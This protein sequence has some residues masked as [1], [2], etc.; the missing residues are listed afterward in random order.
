MDEPDAPWLKTLPVP[1][2]ALG[3]ARTQFS[4][5][6]RWC[7]WLRQHLH[8]FDAIIVHGLWRYPSVGVWRVCHPRR[9][10]FVYVHGM[11]DPKFRRLF[12]FKHMAKT[13]TWK[14]WEHRVVRDAAA[15]LFTCA[16][17][18][19]L[20]QNSFR[21]YHAREAIVPYC[22]AEPPGDPPSQR[23]AFESAFPMLQGKTIILFLSR[24]HPKKGCDVLL[25][26]FSRVAKLHPALRLVMAG[27]DPVGWQAA[28]ERHARQLGV[29]DR[30]LWTG[31]LTGD[32]KWGAFRSADLFVLPSH[33]EN[34]GIAVVEALAC[35]VPVLITRGVNIWREIE[36][37]GAGLIIEHPSIPV[38]EEALCRWLALTPTETAN[39]RRQAKRCFASRFRSDE[40]ARLLLE[41]LR[42][43]GAKG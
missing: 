6:P 23:A 35:G 22:V 42:A 12:P 29:A 7:P 26:A 5:T 8:E 31:M 32:L 39:I 36:S 1:C 13:L 28:L 17:E 9:P 41:T 43:F 11:L 25:D 38:L 21:P 16:E 20:A 2:T 27:P 15:L 34:F 40:A 19:R 4:Y 14:L 30:I 37:D 3:P 24:I 33:Q 10:Y 18:R